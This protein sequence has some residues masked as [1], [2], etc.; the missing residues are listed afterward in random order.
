M[1]LVRG[2]RI[3]HILVRLHDVIV[4]LR[5]RLQILE[6]FAEFFFGG[7]V[8]VPVALISRSLGQTSDAEG[9]ERRTVRWARVFQ[10]SYSDST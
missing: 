6:Q 7:G 1:R 9:C 2:K 8:H 10:F 3:V 4:I 5:P